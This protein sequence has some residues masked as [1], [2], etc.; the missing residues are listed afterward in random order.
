MELLPGSFIK[1]STDQ[2]KIFSPIIF[3]TISKIFL[4]KAMSVASGI[5]HCELILLYV[6]IG[7]GSD[8][9]VLYLF[10][11]ASSSSLNFDAS[12]CVKILIGNKNPFF[13]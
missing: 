12:F 8:R 7:I 13:Q 1:N 9:S 11:I 5:T 6:F 3:S 10:S 4:S 2:S